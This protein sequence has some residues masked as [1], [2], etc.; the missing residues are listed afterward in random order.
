M[1]NP[2]SQTKQNQPSACVRVSLF[3]PCVCVCVA[4]SIFHK[5]CAH[6]KHTEARKSFSSLLLRDFHSTSFSLPGHSPSSS[7]LSSS[8]SFSNS[9]PRC[10]ACPV[11]PSHSDISAIFLLLSAL[12]LSLSLP[13]PRWFCYLPALFRFSLLFHLFL[14]TFRGLFE[15]FPLASS[16]D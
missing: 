16:F 7:V 1:K 2:P 9:S 4:F 10:P 11:V 6:N 5:G 3:Y 8:L 14:T 13:V 15:H 12:S